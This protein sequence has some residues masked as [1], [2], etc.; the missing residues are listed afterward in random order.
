MAGATALTSVFAGSALLESGWADAVRIV[1]RNGLIEAITTGA[2]PQPGDERHEF[3]VPGMPN[4][5][6]HAFQ[7]AMAGLAEMRGAGND[8]FWS[9]RTAMYRL[10]LTI[11]PAQLEAVAAQLYVEML[12]AGFTR[13]GEFHYLHH[14]PAG[15]PYADPAELAG[16][17]AA[18][19]RTSGMAL[20]LLPVFYAQSG[21]AAAPPRPEQRRFVQTPD[22]YARLVEACHAIVAGIGGARLGIAPHSL[23]AVTPAQLHEIMPLAPDGPVHIHV[24]EQV[25]EVEGCLTSLG[26][27]PVEWLLANA[28]IDARWTLVHATHMNMAETTGAAQSGAIAGLCPITEANLG[29]GTFPAPA[30]L[31]GK[32]RFGV[33]SDSNVAISV[34]GE[35]RQLEYSQRLALQSRNVMTLPGQSTG[36]QLFHQAVTGGAL[37][38]GGGGHLR[39]GVEAAF[40]SLNTSACAFPT[41]ASLLDQW[42]FSDTIGV[43]SVWVAGRKLVSRGRHISRDE[44]FAAFRRAMSELMRE[45]P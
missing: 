20:T 42:I 13:V 29:D 7:R 33:G 6:S 15:M 25:G 37:S 40:I 19:A 18:A 24:A 22:S 12:E 41:R 31:A 4:L 32:G 44:T 1:A 17:I 26:A 38:L 28:P 5:H 23:R 34:P 9:W 45:L 39:E 2:A 43:D 21:F 11:S 8:S 30:W 36:E 27:R 3:I 10:A 16:R 35:L 14:D